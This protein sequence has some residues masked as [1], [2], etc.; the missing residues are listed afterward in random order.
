MVP[1]S[2]ALL[3][4]MFVPARLCGAGP[5][6][7]AAAAWG[8]PEVWSNAALVVPALV[9]LGQPRSAL[10]LGFAA[11][12]ALLAAGSTYLRR[13]QHDA[14]RV[15]AAVVSERAAT[16]LVLALVA[17]ALSD[18]VWPGSFAIAAVA[19]AGVLMA[20]VLDCAHGGGLVWPLARVAM[21]AVFVLWW[22]TTPP[23]QFDAWVGGAL[24]LAL[25]ADA[26]GTAWGDAPAV[27]LSGHAWRRV[28]YA[29]SL[30]CVSVWIGRPRV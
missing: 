2:I 5:P 28:I 12:V 9:A 16:T 24:A 21:I 19:A 23:L 6:S 4:S 26:V 11:A 20:G 14:S 7:A 27:G 25:L 15:A 1:T 10:T 8:D 18:A 29:A 22:L 13:V 17:G 3:G 30:A